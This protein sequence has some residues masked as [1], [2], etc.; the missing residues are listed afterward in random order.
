MNF[1]TVISWISSNG[2]SMVMAM[3]SIIAA[4]TIIARLTPTQKDD[5]FIAKFQVFFEKLSNMFL[6]NVGA[7]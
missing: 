1:I 7:K 6:P 5:N 4:A 3:T 2:T